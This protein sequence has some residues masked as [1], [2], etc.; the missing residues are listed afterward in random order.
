[1]EKTC[2]CGE[3]FNSDAVYTSHECVPQLKE[4]IKELEC[5]FDKNKHAAEI[6]NAFMTYYER[7]SELK[8]YDDRCYD[9][10]ELAKAEHIV[11]NVISRTRD[12]LVHAYEG[13]EGEPYNT[14]REVISAKFTDV[15]E[16]PAPAAPASRTYN[17]STDDDMNESTGYGWPFVPPIETP[18]P[19]SIGGLPP[20]KSSSIWSRSPA[21]GHSSSKWTAHGPRFT[22]ISKNTSGPWK[23]S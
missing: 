14:I 16:V 11:D 23:F 1:M 9:A 15:L 12:D 2:I 22:G 4:R 3:N 13:I 5:F 8:S 18:A 21:L 19:K 6:A 7:T 20:F 10:I 17:F